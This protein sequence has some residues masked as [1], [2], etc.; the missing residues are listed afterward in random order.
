MTKP[1]K[2]VIEVQGTAIAVIS[3]KD[4][5]FISLTDMLKAKDGDFFI[6]DW[7]RNRKPKIFGVDSPSPDNP[8]DRIYPVHLF[9]R[10]S[11]VTPTPGVAASNAPADVASG[12]VCDRVHIFYYDWYGAP[13]NE[14]AYADTA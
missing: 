6:S 13:P 9:S 7:L 5:D 10:A 11:G 2:N 8:A 12:D 4:E 1:R 14:P 3:Y